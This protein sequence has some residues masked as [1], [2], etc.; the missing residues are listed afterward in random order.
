VRVAKAVT[1]GENIQALET[2]SA[3]GG[4]EVTKAWTNVVAVVVIEVKLPV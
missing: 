2:K 3:V 1:V 4:H